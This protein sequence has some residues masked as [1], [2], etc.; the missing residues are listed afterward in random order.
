[1]GH[2]SNNIILC[3]YVPL[4]KDHPACSSFPFPFEQFSHHWIWQ[5]QNPTKSPSIRRLCLRMV[6]RGMPIQPNPRTHRIQTIGDNNGMYTC[7]WGGCQ[8][9]MAHRCSHILC[10]QVWCV[11][12]CVCVP[13]PHPCTVQAPGY[14]P[15]TDVN[16]HTLAHM[17]LC[18][19]F[20]HTHN[21]MLAPHKHALPWSCVEVPNSSHLLGHTNINVSPYVCKVGYWQLHWVVPFQ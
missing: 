1:M 8:S 21:S 11:C 14:S 5:F 7:T 3:A 13:S 20:K 10:K 9:K 2:S 19:K 17:Q 6:S 18:R 16:A 15:A 4:C 12:V